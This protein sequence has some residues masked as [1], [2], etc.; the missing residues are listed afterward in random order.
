ML[1]LP[2]RSDLGTLQ[3]LDSGL[4]RPSRSFAPPPGA[5]RAAA[6]MRG[7]PFARAVFWEQLY[8]ILIVILR[9]DRVALWLSIFPEVRVGSATL[10]GVAAATTAER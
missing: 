5:P 7:G 2:L 6:G 4:F 9:Q 8:D 1:K 10:S 3:P